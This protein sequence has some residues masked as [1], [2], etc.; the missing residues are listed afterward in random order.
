MSCFSEE[1]AALFSG[2]AAARFNTSFYIK[3]DGCMDF[4]FSRWATVA[5]TTLSGGAQ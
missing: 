1:D 4:G 5:L 3:G 2:G